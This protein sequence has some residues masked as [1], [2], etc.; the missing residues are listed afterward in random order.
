[1]TTSERPG[2]LVLASGDR[3]AII[4]GSG[5]LPRSVT[6]GLVQAGHR[7]LVVAIEGEADFEDEP[8]RYDL[9]RVAPERLGQVMA[10]LKRK[11]VTHLVLAGGV[12][13]RPPL[14]RLRYSPKVLLYLPRLIGGYARGDDGL[15]RAIFGFIQSYGIRVVGAHEVVPDLLAPEGPL[16]KVRPT[17]ADERDIAAALAAART[18]GRLDIGQAAVAI[19][20]RVIALEDIDGTDGLLRRTK[21]LRSH[22]RLAG[23]AR[24]VLVKC[25]KP[26]QE[27][28]VDLPAI[29]PQTVRDAQAAGLAGIAV[30]AE[31]SFV[32]DCSQTVELADEFG[33]FLVGVARGREE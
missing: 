10:T 11:G 32:L 12:A 29:G 27:M 2:S 3:I 7:P 22:G 15:L 25:T 26:G 30:E 9:L 1:M 19:G 8:A 5:L 14:G 16:T 20:G 28:R 4:A 17:R 31:R 21:A 23:K 13:K 24:G 6:D 33:L 18:I